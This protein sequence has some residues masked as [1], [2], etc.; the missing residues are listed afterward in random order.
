MS[1][2]GE[3]QQQQQQQQ[4]PQQRPNALQHSQS[5]DKLRSMV[6][7]VLQQR[8]SGDA[9]G[10]Q[11]QQPSLE[12]FK[13]RLGARLRQQQQQQQPQMSQEDVAE[14]ESTPPLVPITPSSSSFALSQSRSSGKLRDM[15]TSIVTRYR[16]ILYLSWVLFS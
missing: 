2:L 11:Q 10:G 16:K 13:E 8:G 7:T 9:A 3:Q 6:G 15:L 5:S 12:V 14:E 4:Q 1:L